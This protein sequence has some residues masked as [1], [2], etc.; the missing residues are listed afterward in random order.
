MEFALNLRIKELGKTFKIFFVEQSEII[1][2][3]AFAHGDVLLGVLRYP[4]LSPY[5]RLFVAQKIGSVMKTIK[6]AKFS[7][8]ENFI[9]TPSDRDFLDI[10]GELLE[11]KFGVPLY[12]FLNPYINIYKRVSLPEINTEGKLV[13]RGN[14][15][16][17]AKIGPMP[18][19]HPIEFAALTWWNKAIILGPHSVLAKARKFII[20]KSNTEIRI[21]APE[22]YF[23]G[24]GKFI[25]FNGE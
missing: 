22:I 21:K 18:T 17:V 19:T 15:Y 10:L 13:A 1:D 2:P 4:G 5:N 8:P 20:I 24:R 7:S 9:I 14:Q 16:I 11:A 6:V 23:K 3:C 12:F 25:V